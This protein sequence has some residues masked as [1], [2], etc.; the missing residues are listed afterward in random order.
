MKLGSDPIFW[1]IVL[2]LAG[3]GATAL[4]IINLCAL[5]YSCGCQ[6]WWA[7]AATAC[8]IH[9]ME[10]RHCPWCSIGEFGFYSIVA[11]IILAQAVISFAPRPASWIQRI[12]YTFLVFPVIGGAIGFALGLYQ[13]YWK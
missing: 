1:K 5:I 2:F 6:S 3:S 9:H 13:G 10:S 4:F 11:I 8:N 12:S 7:G